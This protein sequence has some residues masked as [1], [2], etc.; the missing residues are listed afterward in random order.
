MD[1]SNSKSTSI[2]L[3][4]TSQPYKLLSSNTIYTYTQHF[5]RELV[6]HTE[7]KVSQSQSHAV[8]VNHTKHCP[9]VLRI[10]R[11]SLNLPLTEV[12]EHENAVQPMLCCK[13]CEASKLLHPPHKV[14][15][16]AGATTESCSCHNR[17]A[18]LLQQQLENAIYGGFVTGYFRL[19]T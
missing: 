7:Y 15:L 10:Y 5:P 9:Q 14:Q 17:V 12:T 19:S 1:R 4:S 11:F 16:D 8:L 3:S 18:Q 13:E 2:T 6:N